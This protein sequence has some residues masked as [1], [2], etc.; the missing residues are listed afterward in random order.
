MTVK[1]QILKLRKEG[2]TYDEIAREVECSKGTISYHCGKGQKEKSRLR[3]LKEKH[4][5]WKR[6]YRRN[7]KIK[8]LEMFGNKCSRCGYDK[9][10]AALHFHHID[11]ENKNFD[12]RGK[13]GSIAFDKCVEEAKKCIVLC[14]NCH[15]E[16]HYK[17]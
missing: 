5:L 11:P 16:E 10:P 8:L 14:A 12:M 3:Q 4:K 7:Q 15:A 13:M 17:D 9:S 1:E 2:K 6:E